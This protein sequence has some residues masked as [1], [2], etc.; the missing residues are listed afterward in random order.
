M[1]HLVSTNHLELCKNEK[2]KIAINFFE[3][4]F[5]AYS[6]KSETSNLEK[7]DTQFLAVQF[8]NKATKRKV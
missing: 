5:S 1:D 8:C 6:N 3:M 7:K 2:D 4:I